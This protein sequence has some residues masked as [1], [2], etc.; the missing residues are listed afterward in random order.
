M[1]KAVLLNQGEKGTEAKLTEL[2][3]SSLPPG[4][5]TVQVEYSSLNYKDALAI[6]G[7]GPVVRSFPMVPGIDL[8]GVIDASDDPRWKRGERV[9]VNGWGMGEKHWGGLAQRVRVDG[10]WLLPLSAGLSSWGAMA[11]GTA[12]YTAA[13]CVDGLERHGVTPDSGEILVTGAGGGVGGFAI[14][15]LARRGYR[16]TA[17]TG[18]PDLESYL[19]TL[20]VDGIIAR[21]RLSHPGKPLAE[22][23][24]AGAIDTLGGVTLANVC[25]GMAY[26]GVVTACGLAQGMDFPATVAPFILRGVTLVGIDSVY[27][28]RPE[29]AAAWERLARDLEPNLLQL[30]ART[31][32]LGEVVAMAPELLAGRVRGRLVVDVAG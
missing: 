28:P 8:S 14:A 30:I 5:V 15:L 27:A 24:W 3:E 11:I 22:A 20:G 19:K 4:G 13:L 10:D 18:R 32:G 6:T 12:G 26:R 1:F 31:I 2:D 29:R 21:E 9:I 23:R 17:V 7:A 16:V 25:A